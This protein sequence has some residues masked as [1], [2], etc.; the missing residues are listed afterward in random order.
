VQYRVGIDIGGTFTDI[1]LA[2]DDGTRANCKVLTTPGDFGRAIAEGLAQLMQRH[3]LAPG[4]IARIVHATT[5]ATNAILEGKGAATGLITTEGFRDVLEMRRLRIPEMYTLGY[6]TPPPLVPRRLRLEVAERM[7]PRGEVRRPLDEASAHA[8]AERLAAAGVEAVAVA[9]LHAYANSAHE[10]RVAEIVAAALPN[11]FITCSSD[12]LP[13]IREY[14]RTSTTVINAYLGPI[15]RG[16]F[17]S[18]KKH[19]DALG[20]KA[21]VDI[22][23]SDGGVM[24]MRMAA[25]KPA[26]LVESGPAAGVIGAAKLGVRI[27]GQNGSR[28]CLTLD[29]GGTTAKASIVEKGQVARTGDYEVGA[30]INLSSKLVMG[31]GYALKLPVIDI[32]E[33][34]AGGGSIVSVDRG[35]LLHV[36]PKSAGAA[37]GPVVYDRGGTDPTFTDAV[38]ALGY[39]NPARLLGG[40]LPLNAAKARAVLEERVAKPLGRDLRDTAYGIFEVACGTMV[41][42]VKAVSTYRGRDPRDFALFAFGGNGPVVGAA[43]ADLLEMREVVVPPDPGVFSAVGLLMSDIEQE[44]SRAFLRDLATIDARALEALYAEIEREIRADLAADGYRA[45]EVTLARFADLRY[46]GQAHELLVPYTADHAA[47]AEAFGAEHARTYGHR[48]E[49]EAVECVALRVKGRVA[50]AT[51]DASA[52]SRRHADGAAADSRTAYFGPRHGQV[53]VPVLTRA[54]LAAGTRAGPLI[55]EEYD[56]TVVV[57]PGWRARVDAAASIHLSRE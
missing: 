5:V 52:P 3:K 9:L 19:L 18:L 35:G 12:I 14:E 16:Y 31:G 15:L 23:K 49:A 10:Q 22:M 36:G 25:E 42:A 43:I 11:A 8:A 6:R 37:P 44:R 56:S 7:G 45:E 29:M 41:R 2:G 48:A 53:Q 50:R 57:P 4:Q 17:A 21:P 27:G 24:S 32:S 34:G 55:V 33:I 54:A 40:D 47:M 28:D 46:A 1:V 30:G 13:E 26:Y 20:I 38:V 51:E 39:L